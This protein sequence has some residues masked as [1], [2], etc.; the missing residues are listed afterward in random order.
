M[1][2]KAIEK[3]NASLPSALGTVSLTMPGDEEASGIECEPSETRWQEAQKCGARPQIILQLDGVLC[4]A[5]HL[6][7]KQGKPTTQP[8]ATLSGSA[9]RPCQFL[10]N[11]ASSYSA[12]ELQS[13]ASSGSEHHLPGVWLWRTN[14]SDL[15][16]LP[17]W[18]ARAFSSSARV[19]GVQH[20]RCAMLCVCSL[21]M[22][23]AWLALCSA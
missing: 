14:C 5:S 6:L 20:D 3:R 21:H 23:M 2:A 10:A 16:H 12:H 7:C 19:L 15:L 17:H 18:A 4:S 9:S 11:Q 22:R 1:P 13:T 8:A